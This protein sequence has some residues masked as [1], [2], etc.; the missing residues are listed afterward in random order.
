LLVRLKLINFGI[1]LNSEF[2]FTSGINSIIGR[3]GSGKSS[4]LNAIGVALF[5][6][7]SNVADFVSYGQD[8]A[9]V[10]LDFIWD[11]T[12]Y[13]ISR[14]FGKVSSCNLSTPIETITQVKEVYSYLSNLFGIDLKTYYLNVVRIKSSSITYPFIT[15]VS[16]RKIIFDSIFE[17]D[18]YGHIWEF[19]REPMKEL[20]AEMAAIQKRVEFERGRVSELGTVKKQLIDVIETIK[21]LSKEHQIYLDNRAAV[22]NK[23]SL[24]SRIQSISSNL[25]DLNRERLDI[26]G[27]LN[28]AINRICYACGQVISSEAAFD[29]RQEYEQRLEGL[30]SVI[31]NNSTILEQLKQQASRI[32]YIPID[33]SVGEKLIRSKERKALLENRYKELSTSIID[34]L[35]TEATSLRTAIDRLGKVRDGFRKLPTLLSD[36]NTANVSSISSE[37]LSSLMDRPVAVIFDQNYNLT[38]EFDDKVLEFHQLSDGQQI[39]AGLSI[40]MAIIKHFSD[41]GFCILDEPSVNL[42]EESRELL[43]EN[44]IETQ[45]AQI[46]LVSHDDIFENKVDNIIRL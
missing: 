22:D 25:N 2:H 41:L 37:I 21:E 13:K 27:R 7:Y 26:E 34:N 10:E 33:Y 5:N 45:F 31:S 19:L 4:I 6:A 11:N 16:K 14:Q 36:R 8:S 18:K 38:F 29:N 43:A 1:H 30:N 32:V 44:I 9:S 35:Q 46:L 28:D 3:N 42:D 15:E 39:L 40:R 17:L 23:V 24:E 12:P 20:N